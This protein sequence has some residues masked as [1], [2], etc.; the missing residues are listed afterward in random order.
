MLRVAGMAHGFPVVSLHTFRVDHMRVSSTGVRDVLGQGD[1]ERAERLLGR[2]YRMVGR[3]AHGDKRGRMIGVPT[4]NLFLHRRTAPLSGVYV[5]EMFGV[6][7]EPQP[8]VANIGTRPTAGGM[9]SLLEVHLLDF[10]GDIYGR[11][12]EVDFL[13]RIREERRFA[14]FE[15]LRAQIAIDMQE[16]R[17]FFETLM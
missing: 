11:Y 15:E 2:P 9:R 7:G 3:V 10:T 14:S 16:A 5:V 12:V 1:F 8:G 4:A 6:P 17:D 13:H